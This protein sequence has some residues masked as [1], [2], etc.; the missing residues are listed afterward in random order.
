M[1]NVS[2]PHPGCVF[3]A[4]LKLLETLSK[5]Y[6]VCVSNILLIQLSRQFENRPLQ[7]VTEGA[8]LSTWCIWYDLPPSSPLFS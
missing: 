5:T 2:H 8:I 7:T 1:H 4:Q 3:S 6:S